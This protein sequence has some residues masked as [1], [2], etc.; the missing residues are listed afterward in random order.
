MVDEECGIGFFSLSSQTL[1]QPSNELSFEVVLGYVEKRSV[2]L[3]AGNLKISAARGNVKGVCH[4]ISIAFAEVFEAG[5]LFGMTLD[6]FETY[7]SLKLSNENGSVTRKLPCVLKPDS[8]NFIIG[9]E[10]ASNGC[11]KKL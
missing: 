5:K 10:N 2:I 4:G 7:I 3:S 1:I 6:V 8:V 9:T 11:I